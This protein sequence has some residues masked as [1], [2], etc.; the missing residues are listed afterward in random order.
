M[1][2]GSTD[3][4]VQQCQE[5]QQTDKRVQFYTHANNQNLGAGATRNVGMAKATQPYLSFLDSDDY[6]LPN[7]FEEDEKVFDANPMAVGTYNALGVH[8][9][10]DE[11]KSI[12]CA[13]FGVQLEKADQFLTTITQQV[14]PTELFDYLYRINKP[15]VG[16]IHLNGLT[17]QR[18][19]VEKFA[20]RFHDGL[21]LHQDTEFIHRLAYYGNLLPS[22]IETAVAKRGVHSHNRITN[23]GNAFAIYAKRQL[24]YDAVNTWASKENLEGYRQQF[25]KQQEAINRLRSE[26]STL[27][28]IWKFKQWKRAEQPSSESVHSMRSLIFT[29]PIL[30][31]II[32]PLLA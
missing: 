17:L 12:F 10:S 31:K 1:D 2:D 5:W 25:F 18:S 7:R 9:Y 13:Q 14:P 3:D 29:H 6:Y 8:F 26:P 27:K 30:R 19:F 23:K 20:L 4:S 21:R 24:L 15:F 32:S 16:Y 22:Q 28:R 11:A